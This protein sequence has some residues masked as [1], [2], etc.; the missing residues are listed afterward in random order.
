MYFDKQDDESL[1][2]IDAAW[3]QWFNMVLVAVS[4]TLIIH[5]NCF[6]IALRLVCKYPRE[7]IYIASLIQTICGVACHLSRTT[8]F[9][10]VTDCIAKPLHNYTQ[11]WLGISLMDVVVLWR[12]TRM[13]TVL[14]KLA[15]SWYALMWM[16]LGLAPLLSKSV[17]MLLTIS[18]L[19]G[20]MGPFGICQI[21]LIDKYFTYAMWCWVAYHC[22][23]LAL[24][25]I[26]FLDI[27]YII[28]LPFK[29][30]PRPAPTV[31]KG[32]LLLL[33]SDVTTICLLLTLLQARLRLG[34]PDLVLQSMWAIKSKC[35]IEML[36]LMTKHSG[37]PKVLDSEDHAESIYYR[38]SL[39][40]EKRTPLA[41]PHHTP[42]VLK[43]KI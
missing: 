31:D 42:A 34:E 39:V 18:S 36:S 29:R 8:D 11:F 3:F 2:K 33:L 27:N 24:H 35:V 16:F 26:L 17:T 4:F 25:A 15:P 5:L 10:F 20:S 6:F 9:F 12:D 37:K 41:S 19:K 28:S 40:P 22:A 43:S 30:R 7:K 14:F 23:M 1:V 21:D 32:T 13:L 38:R